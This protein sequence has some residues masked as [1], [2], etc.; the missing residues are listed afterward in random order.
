[1]I[2]SLNAN[3]LKPLNKSYL[4][5]LG[6]ISVSHVI[7]NTALEASAPI[8]LTSG[9]EERHSLKN[10][11]GIYTLRVQRSLLS[12]IKTKKKKK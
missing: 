9:F 8:T 4:R 12:N 7:K 6:E 3:Q 2:T 1:M 11:N 10:L 5:S